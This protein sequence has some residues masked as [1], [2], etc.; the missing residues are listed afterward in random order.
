MDNNKTPSFSLSLSLFPPCLTRTFKKILEVETMNSEFT[1]FDDLTEKMKDSNFKK[2]LNEQIMQLKKGTVYPI[3]G[4]GNCDEGYKFDTEEL[5]GI[6]IGVRKVDGILLTPPHEW[7]RINYRHKNPK[8]YPNMCVETV[9]KK[10]GEEEQR[11]CGN[12]MVNLTLVPIQNAGFKSGDKGELKLVKC[13][14]KYTKEQGGGEEFVKFPIMQVNRN[15]AKC[16]K[17]NQKLRCDKCKFTFYCSR[18]CQIVHWKMEGGHKKKCNP[19][20]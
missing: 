15:C 11:C 13:I 9:V 7:L 1:G 14:K 19:V 20:E 10:D 3:S 16:G 2:S 17:K 12:H 18:K 4:K 8:K 6:I 5:A